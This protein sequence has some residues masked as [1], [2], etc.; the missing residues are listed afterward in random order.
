MA[1]TIIEYLSLDMLTTVRLM[2]DTAH[3]SK[4]ETLD[5]ILNNLRLS[6]KNSGGVFTIIGH[7]STCYFYTDNL[8]N[9]SNRNASVSKGTKNRIRQIYRCMNGFSMPD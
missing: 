3:C 4:P 2:V 5:G 7:Y 8:G 6:L 9:W 1:S